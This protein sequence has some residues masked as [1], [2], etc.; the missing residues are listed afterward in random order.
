MLAAGSQ[1][2]KVWLWNIGRPAE[3]V[4]A[5]PLTGATDW[6]N[7][8]AFSPDGTSL[9]AGSS[10]DHVLVWHLATRAAA[11]SLPHPQPVTSLGWDGGRLITGDADGAVRNW[12]LPAPVLLAGGPVNSVA[13]SPDGGMLAVGSQDLELW[14]PGRRTMTA[15]ATAPGT[16]INAVAF[17]PGT[18]PHGGRALAAGYGDGKVQLWQVTSGAE[19]PLGQ[20]MLAST[21]GLAEFV[22]FSHN[23]RLLA[24]AGDDGT[25]RVWSVSDPRRP[26][27]VAILNDSVNY[28]FSVAFSPDGRTLAAASG[29]KFTRLWDITDPARPVPLGKPLTTTFPP[30]T[31]FVIPMALRAAPALSASKFSVCPLETGK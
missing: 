17:A 31:P 21:H 16:F 14:N 6:V 18:G 4:R 25:V 15:T 22:T 19:T 20:P 3:P 30:R 13:F 26:R 7:T 8:V 23:G 24:S 28:V 5:A 11:A 29:D 1:D 10:D 12:A 9:A 27:L 2:D